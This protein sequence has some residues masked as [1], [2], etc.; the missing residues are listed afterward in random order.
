MEFQEGDRV[1]I[2]EVGENDAFYYVETIVDQ[3][4]ILEGEIHQTF[5]DGEFY[6]FDIKFDD[7]ESIGHPT[8]IKE[9]HRNG[10]VAFYK[11]KII[12]YK[13]IDKS[14]LNSLSRRI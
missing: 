5:G 6:S 11:A 14:N 3:T 2:V 9:Q 1:I 13:E 4:G 7:V 8:I 10:N 12:P